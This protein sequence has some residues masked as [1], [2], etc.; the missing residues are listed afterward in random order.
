[1][2]DTHGYENVNLLHNQNIEYYGSEIMADIIIKI[3]I[4]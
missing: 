1:M 4:I 2:R 3:D